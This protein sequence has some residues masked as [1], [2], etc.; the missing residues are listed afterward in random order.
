VAALGIPHDGSD[1]GHVT[2]SV[3]AASVLPEPGSTPADLIGRADTALYEAKRTG[4]DRVCVAR[5][6]S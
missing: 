2:I 5:Q 1:A 3:G 6:I 4:R